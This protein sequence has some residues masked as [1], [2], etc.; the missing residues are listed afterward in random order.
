MDREKISL[1]SHV[2]LAMRMAQEANEMFLNQPLTLLFTDID[3][4]PREIFDKNFSRKIIVNSMFLTR[5]GEMIMKLPV[6]CDIASQNNLGIYPYC[7][8]FELVSQVLYFPYREINRSWVIEGQYAVNFL[9]KYRYQKDDCIGDG[10]GVECQNQ[11][12]QQA[13]LNK[14]TARCCERRECMRHAADTVFRQRNL[15]TL[16]TRQNS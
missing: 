2:C 3:A 10:S 8:S 5:G 12:I 14:A 13:K 1:S 7:A 15:L 9:E 6:T 11:S 16:G 4:F